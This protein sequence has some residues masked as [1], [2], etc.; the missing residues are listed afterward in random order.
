MQD[1]WL[2]FA[3]SGDPSCASVGAWK[4]YDETSRQTMVFGASSKSE[5]APRDEERRAW[6]IA[7]DRA[8]GSL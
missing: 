1:A 6:D 4:A 3:K 5:D 8:L 2:A 7:P